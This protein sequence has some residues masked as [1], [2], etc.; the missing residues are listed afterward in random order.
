MD[1]ATLAGLHSVYDGLSLDQRHH[2]KVIV[3][4]RSEVLSVTCCRSLV[5][6]GLVR[7]DEDSFSATEDGRYIASL[8]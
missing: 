5:G 7:P 3:E 2:L 4:S 6:L 1:D 8:F